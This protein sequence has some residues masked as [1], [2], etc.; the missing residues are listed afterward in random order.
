[1]IKK[2]PKMFCYNSKAMLLYHI[3]L[4][5]LTSYALQNPR[6]INGLHELLNYQR[7]FKMLLVAFCIKYLTF[8]TAMD[9]PVK[10]L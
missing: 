10:N 1:M 7:D 5:L 9:P 6:I 3:L 2:N 8:L 4:W